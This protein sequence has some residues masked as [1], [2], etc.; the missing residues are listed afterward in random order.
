M[1]EPVKTGSTPWA[2]V[3]IAR[4]DHWFKNVF[5]VPGVVIAWLVDPSVR[6]AVGLG[7]V[8]LAI[9]GLCLVASAN[10]AINE[11]LDAPQDRQH[12]EKKHRP[13]ARGAV[14]GP[15]VVALWAI[16]SAAGLGLGFVAAPAAGVALVLLWVMGLVY[17][18]P[19]VRSK[20]V[21]YLDV[22]SE[23]VNNPIRLAVGWWAT[24]IDAWPPLSLLLAYWMLGAFFMGVKRFAEY[25]HIGDPERAASYRKSFRHYD[26]ER[27]LVSV[28]AYAAA[29]AMFSG[30]F[31]MRYRLELVLAV[32]LV[33]VLFG[34]Y[35]HLGLQE[36]SATMAPERLYREPGFA[37]FGLLVFVV[38][39]VLLVVDVPILAD[40]FAPSI[41]PDGW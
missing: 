10:Y 7:G 30:V 8:G 25:R 29:S 27:L 35:L 37:A 23:S 24:G 15:G 3:R 28:M 17:N 41:A 32:P 14:S 31:L 39:V 9:L 2:Y 26:E 16:L 40:V 4:P 33:A 12:P 21:P 38:C 11:Y 6:T 5:A 18:V 22:L 1:S 34:W 36:D 13:A 20:E 19:P